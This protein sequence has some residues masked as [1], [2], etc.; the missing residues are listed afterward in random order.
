MCQVVEAIWKVKK[1][2][3]DT[4]KLEATTADL[5]NISN[6]VKNDV[7]KTEYNELIK[8]ANLLKPS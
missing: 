5:S 8:K 2:K 4:G 1:C 6:V 3:S 7:K